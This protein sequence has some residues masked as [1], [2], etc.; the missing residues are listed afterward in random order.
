M[1]PLSTASA[2]ATIIGLIGQFRTERKAN[3]GDFEDFLSWSETKD[4]EIRSLVQTNTQISVGIKALLARD[5]ADLL[6]RL[7]SIDNILSSI[8]ANF[9]E[10]STLARALSP[11]GALSKQAMSILDQM[12]LGRVSKVLKFE[13]YDGAELMVLEGDSRVINFDDK[14]FLDDDLLTLVEC[15]LLRLSY[16]DSGGEIYTFTR[17]AKALVIETRKS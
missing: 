8:A 14:Q 3:S 7:S 13:D 4:I 11:G 2:F 15:G 16:N 12:E 1:E 17:Q 5:R 9:S 10:F 6:S